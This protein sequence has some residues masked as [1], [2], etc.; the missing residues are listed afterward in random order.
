MRN[1]MVARLAGWT[2]VAALGLGA[3]NIGAAAYAN[4]HLESEKAAPKANHCVDA[5]NDVRR[6][7]V[8]KQSIMVEDGSGRGV[9]L[10][11]SMPCKNLDELDQIGFEFNGSSQICDKRDAKILYSRNGEAPVRCLITEVKH[12]TREQTKAY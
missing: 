7:V 10:T 5:G 2:A 8:D 4:G 6:M 9:L 12:L 11:L 1:L 3:L